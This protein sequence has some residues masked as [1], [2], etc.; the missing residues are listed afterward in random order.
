MSCHFGIWRTM[1]LHNI[2]TLL[3]SLLDTVPD[4]NRWCVS[5]LP[6]MHSADKQSS[7]VIVPLR[8]AHLHDPIR[9]S[10]MRKLPVNMTVPPVLLSYCTGTA[11]VAK[12]S[13]QHLMATLAAF[14]V[15][16]ET[17]CSSSGF[18]FVARSSSSSSSF[19]G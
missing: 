8:N 12:Q 1:A 9:D 19:L 17:S 10:S 11:H 15:P 2:H 4:Q 3:A 6:T 18:N 14:G 16:K 13:R 7:I 5:Y